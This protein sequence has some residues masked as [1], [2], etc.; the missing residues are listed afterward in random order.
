MSGLPVDPT[1][2]PLSTQLN[3]SGKVDTPLLVGKGEGVTLMPVVYIL[4]F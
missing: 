1:V 4:T 3:V 2:Q